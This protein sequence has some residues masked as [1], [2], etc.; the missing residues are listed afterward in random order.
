MFVTETNLFKLDEKNLQEEFDLL[1][2]YSGS[3]KCPNVC[4][5]LKDQIGAIF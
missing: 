3:K 1:E 4:L 2:A 5:I